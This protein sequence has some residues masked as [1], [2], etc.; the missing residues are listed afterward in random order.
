MVR[1][2][3]AGSRHSWAGRDLVRPLSKRGWAQ[4]EALADRFGGA[5]VTAL[6]SSPFTRCV[7]TLEPLA[8][9]LGL[10]VETDDRLAEGAAFEQ[11]LTLLAEAGEGA[12]LCSHGDV[13]PDLITALQRRGM[14]IDTPPDWRKATVWVLERTGDHVVRGSV[15]PPPEV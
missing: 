5:P 11:A 4:A 8:D 10:T 12:V 7:Q 14:V 1:H 9:R 2:A 15:E 3:K 13:V 6:I